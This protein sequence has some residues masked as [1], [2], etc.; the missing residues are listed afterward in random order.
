VA[1]V[2]LAHPEGGGL[3]AMIAGLLGA[4]VEDPAKA[5]LLDSMRGGVTIVV[6]DA[7]VEVGLRFDGGV[8]TVTPRGVPGSDLQITMASDV[9]LGLSTVPLLLGLPSVL[10]ADGRAFTRKLLTREVRIR[11]LRHVL[12]LTQLTRLLS[13]V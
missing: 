2:V 12:L 1:Q 13:L 10:S 3:D 9:L 5:T 11:G 8:C 4:A 7:E 6:P